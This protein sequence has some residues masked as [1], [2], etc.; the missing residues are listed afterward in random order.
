MMH[1]DKAVQGFAAVFARPDFSV[2]PLKLLNE[3][4]YAPGE[5]IHRLGVRIFDNPGRLARRH[6]ERVFKG[7]G[8]E[9]T[10]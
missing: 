9:A 3:L 7:G 5:V 10:V 2:P 6:P 1:A 4:A 8:A